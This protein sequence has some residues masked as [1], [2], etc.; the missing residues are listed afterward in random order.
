MR[1]ST[2]LYELVN[3]KYQSMSKEDLKVIIQELI[4]YATE[5]MDYK[6]EDEAFNDI[7]EV[8]K[9]HEIIWTVKTY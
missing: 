7:F 5:N 6:Q 2:L 3:E 1:K 4:Y 8:L 9:A